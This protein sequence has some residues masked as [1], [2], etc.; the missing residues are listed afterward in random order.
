VTRVVKVGGRAQADISLAPTIAKVWKS[1]PGSLCLVHGGGDEI[2]E[3][4]KRLGLEPK[5]QNGRRVTTA[6][7][8]LVV[9]MVLSGIA[10]KRLVSALVREG[11]AAI[12]LSG[13]D[14]GMMCAEPRDKMVFGFVG[15]TPDVDPAILTALL[16]E[17]LLPVISPV[18]ACS[19]S[20]FSDALNVNGDDAAAAIA[21]ALGAE[22]LVF[23][24]DVTGVRESSGRSLGEL[25]S[26]SA[27]ELMKNGTAAGGMAAKLES[28]LFALAGGV[29]KVRIGAIEMLQDDGAGTLIRSGTGV[30]R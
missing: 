9:R 4:Q 6:D 15:K 7:D 1:S 8:L 30:G 23:V 27:R 28:A 10:N 13:E 26:N 11:I 21:I 5:M 19:D 18:S 14:G 29:S 22:E 24:S 16:R 12:G 2:S 17:K 3:T 20:S 25:D